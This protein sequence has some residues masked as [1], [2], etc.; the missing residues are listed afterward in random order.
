LRHARMIAGRGGYP[1]RMT[2][3]DT[4]AEDGDESLVEHAEEDLD[5]SQH[6]I[7][8]AKSA[9]RQASEFDPTRD[10]DSTPYPSE[11]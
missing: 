6:T 5:D 8:E 10:D 2:T 7:D 1:P 9:A 4:T 11:S 3:D